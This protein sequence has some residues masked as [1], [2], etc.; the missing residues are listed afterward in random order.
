MFF[1]YNNW[2]EAVAFS[3]GNEHLGGKLILKYSFLMCIVLFI[4]VYEYFLSILI[5]ENLSVGKFILNSFIDIWE[6]GLVDKK[7]CWYAQTEF[8]D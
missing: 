1:V 2:I 6:V 5:F 3:D 4:Y 7:Y 8:S